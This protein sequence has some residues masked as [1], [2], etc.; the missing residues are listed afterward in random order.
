MRSAHVSGWSDIMIKVDNTRTLNRR[1]KKLSTTLNWRLSWCYNT[2]HK[3]MAENT[4]ITS[5]RMG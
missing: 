1:M 3:R 2:K 4:L 5:N